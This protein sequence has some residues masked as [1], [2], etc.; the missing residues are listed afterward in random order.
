MIKKLHFIF[1]LLIS[2]YI[3]CQVTFDNKLTLIDQ[4]HFSNDVTSIFCDDLNND[5]KKDLIVASY[6]DNSIIWYKNLEG[7]YSNNQRLIISNQIDTPSS[8]Y[9]K[10]LDNDGLKDIIA[11]SQYQNYIVW[12]RNLNNNN[13]SP[14]ITI[15][16]SVNSPKS[17]KSEDIDNDGDSDIIVGCYGNSSVVKFTN[18]GNGTFQNL[19]NLYITNSGTNKINIYDINNDGFKDVISGHSD[20]SIYFSLNLNNGNFG[21]NQYIIGDADSGTAFNFLDVNQDGYIDLIAGSKYND[22]LKYYLNLNGTSFDNGHLINSTNQDPNEIIIHDIDNDGRKDIVVSYWTNNKIGWYKN[23]GT[24]NFATFITITTNVTYPKSFIVEDINIDGQ[25][26]IVSASYGS[27]TPTK[28]SSFIYTSNNNYKEIIINFYPIGINKTK[29]ADLNNDGRKDI[30]SGYK[31]IVWNKNR[32]DNN[33]SSYKLITNSLP[34]SSTFVNDFEIEDIDNDNDLDIISLTNSSLEIYINQGNESFQLNY[35][36]ALTNQ[37]KEIEICDINGDN[38]KDILL[39]FAS[40]TIKLGIITNLGNNSYSS[41]N[42]ISYTGFLYTPNQI[43][44]GDIDNDGD[45]DILI[46]SSLSSTIQWLENNG[47]GVFQTHLITQSI[48]T[49]VILLEDLDNDSFL[50]IITCG[51][52]SYSSSTIYWIKNNGNGVFSNRIFIGNQSA[53]AL[54]CGDINNDNLKDIVGVSYQYYS[55]YDEKVFA[56]LNSNAGFG[57]QIVIDSLGDAVSLSRNINLGDINN[58]NKLDIATSYYQIGRVDYFLNSST[59]EVIDYLKDEN[60]DFILYPI[61]FTSNLNWKQSQNIEKKVQINI[62]SEEGKLIY[63]KSNINNNSINL[64]FLKNGVYFINFKSD[65]KNITKKII[66]H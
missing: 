66:K 49:D 3:F 45:K 22:N 40:G 34:N 19:E 46:S 33:F 61:P 62:Y 37:S 53:K 65:Q 8:V 38:L 52:N 42:T 39:T 7:D 24:T 6:Y 56:Y 1:S 10:D 55:P 64:D 17:I 44:S 18:N 54:D 28:L 14:A 15:S 29:I 16:N 32:S 51:S 63:S 9:V 25:P 2:N 36:L 50:D 26:D 41:L 27:G 30:I 21:T 43:K 23:L 35:S 13:F 12:Y 47:N 20:G 60:K 48:T 31:S 4:S 57:N 59:L 58:D 5:S 11:C